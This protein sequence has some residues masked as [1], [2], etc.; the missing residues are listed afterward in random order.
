MADAGST[1]SSRERLLRLIRGRSLEACLESRRDNILALR[2]IA[3]LLVIFGHSFPLAEPLS[4]PD[5]PIRMLLP[6]TASYL[7]GLMM[8]FTISGFLISLSYIRNPDLVRFLRARFLRIWP[9]LAVVIVL[10][11]FVFGPLLSTLSPAQYFATAGT[12]ADAYTY[13][14]G[15]ILIFDIHRFL[16]GVFEHNPI[17]RMVNGP[18]WSIVAEAKLYL[19]VAGAGTLRLFRFPRIAS[20]MIAAL[21]AWL[22]AS[23]F[24]SGAFAYENNLLLVVQGFF[25]AGAIACLLRRHIPVSTPIMAVVAAACVLS[26]TTPYETPCTWLA[27]GYGVLWFSYIPRLP[28]I[29]HGIDLSYGAYLWAWPIQQAIVSFGVRRPTLLIAIGMPV[30]LAFAALSWFLVE[31]PALRLKDRSRRVETPAAAEAW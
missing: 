31:R 1:L 11:A 3:A 15:G 12:G 20:A 18:L 30:I 27:I 2:L 17:P 28:Q 10:W 25:G 22:F 8:F 6:R 29:P 9:A 21:L 13:A 14:W 23:A 4:W 26:R 24:A 16:P 19:W 7:V 5:D